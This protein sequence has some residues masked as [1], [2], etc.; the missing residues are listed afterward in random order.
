MKNK[1]LSATAI[2]LALATGSALA[3]DLPSRKEA[4][5]YVA[6]APVATWTGFYAGLNLGGG[7][8]SQGGNNS[9]L[10]Y[11]D[12]TFGLGSTPVAGLAPNLFFLPGGGTTGNNTGGVVGGGQIGYNYQ[13]NQFVLGVETDFQGTSI[14]GGNQGNYAGLYASPYP[15]SATGV[16]SPLVTGNGGNLGL[17]WF[18]TVRGRAGYLVTPTLLLYGTGGFAYG[19]VEAFQ[20]SNTSTGWTAGGGV[21][22]M[23]MPHWTAKLEYL[24][25]DLDSSG[26][27]GAFTGWQLGNNHHPQLNVVRLGVNYLFNFGAP[28]PV[29]AKY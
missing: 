1:L 22:W 17:P 11:A 20:R 27:N 29:L 15:T 24:Y 2:A 21:E 9:Y 19:G 23:F 10:P 3:A 4:P 25:V 8:S 26:I 18:G 14:T 28:A 16:L 5:V 7:W 13:M 6:P 12:S